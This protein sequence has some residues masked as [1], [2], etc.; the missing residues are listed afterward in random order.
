MCAITWSFLISL[1]LVIGVDRS[2]RAIAGM[3]RHD[4]SKYLQKYDRTQYKILMKHEIK[5]KWNCF[6]FDVYCKS[7]FHAT[8]WQHQYL[9]NR[10]RGMRVSSSKTTVKSPKGGASIDE[11]QLPEAL[12]SPEVLPR[13]QSFLLMPNYCRFSFLTLSLKSHE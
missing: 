7:W 8:Y 11:F 9:T 6:L 3:S 5:W 13:F 2:C 1:F 10:W 12:N 4:F